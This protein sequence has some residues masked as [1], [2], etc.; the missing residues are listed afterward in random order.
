MLYPCCMAIVIVTSG[1]HYVLDVVGG[2]VVVSLAYGLTGAFP[3]AKRIL[4]PVSLGAG[5]FS[6]NA[7]E[8]ENAKTAGS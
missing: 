7:L 8:E 1:H 2:G 4:V 3:R 5:L 6:A